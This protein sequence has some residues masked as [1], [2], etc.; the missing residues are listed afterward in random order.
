ML[1]SKVRV[2]GKEI[3]SQKSRKF[4]DCVSEHMYTM[5]M[6]LSLVTV[7]EEGGIEGKKRGTADGDCGYQTYV[8]FQR[9]HVAL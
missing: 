9:L 7:K 1:E 5:F 3:N 2:S 4:L 6:L 8:P